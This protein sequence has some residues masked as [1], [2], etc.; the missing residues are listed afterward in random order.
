MCDEEDSSDN[1]GCQKI[2]CKTDSKNGRAKRR[3]FQTLCENENNFEEPLCIKLKNKVTRK[4]NR[5]ML[6]QVGKP[7]KRSKSPIPRAIKKMCRDEAAEEKDD[8]ILHKLEMTCKKM[9]ETIGFGENEAC[10]CVGNTDYPE[11]LEGLRSCVKS[12]ML[13]Y[14][15]NDNN[16]KDMEKKFE[17]QKMQRCGGTNGRNKFGR[18]KCI[19]DLC[20]EE[21]FADICHC[22]NG[23]LERKKCFKKLEKVGLK[24]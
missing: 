22:K 12:T 18:R 13:D 24:I 19:K 16:E 2:R 23:R 3:C 14:C 8:C 15:Q 10:K 17:C 9:N 21:I 4:T 1:F 6:R 20:K 5:K 11:T 7:W